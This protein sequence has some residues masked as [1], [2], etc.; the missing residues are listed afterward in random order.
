MTELVAIED[1]GHVRIIR[2]N[3]ADKKN[4]LNE[5]LAWSVVNAVED[6]A[7]DDDV[8]V[9]G[10]TGTGDAFCA[11]LDLSGSGERATPHGPISD[12]LD[13]I[14]WVGRFLLGLRDD[15]DKP[16][17]AGING[18]AVGPSVEK[19]SAL[20][21]H[22]VQ[23]V[24]ERAKLLEHYIPRLGLQTGELYSRMCYKAV[25]VGV[26]GLWVGSG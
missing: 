25:W 20:T 6:A 15:C 19:R 8:W 2:L 5:A 24:E 9:I 14:H 18:V 12:R 4:A 23:L 10:I 16:V 17:V 21:V 26:G 3:R 13:D 7:R 22:K 11:G 1:R